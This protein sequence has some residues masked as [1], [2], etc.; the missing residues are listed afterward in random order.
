MTADD[1]KAFIKT[2]CS[3]HFVEDPLTVTAS[4]PRLKPVASQGQESPLYL[5]DPLCHSVGAHLFPSIISEKVHLHFYAHQ[6]FI[7]LSKIF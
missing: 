2:G 3:F 1:T 6:S 5:I 7:A 4:H